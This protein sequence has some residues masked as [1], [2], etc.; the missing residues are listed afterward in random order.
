MLIAQV[1]YSYRPT[2]GGQE[3]LIQQMNELFSRLGHE[4]ITFQTDNGAEEERNLVLVKNKLPWLKGFD[5][6]SIS[7]SMKLGPYDLERF[8][9]VIFHY[10]ISWLPFRRLKNALVFSH[11]VEWDQMK[12][13]VKGIV[14]KR[15]AQYSLAR[16]PLVY[17]VANDKNYLRTVLENDL[18]F[19]RPYSRLAEGV[20]YIPNPVDVKKFQSAEPIAE[21]AALNP[22]LMPRN[23]VRERGLHIA[24]ESFAEVARD[25]PALH[26]IVA[27]E[28]WYA[29][30]NEYGRYISSLIRRNRLQGKVIFVGSIPWVD[31]ARYYKSSLVTVIPT[32]VGEGTSLA[33]LESMASGTPVVSSSTGGLS[34]LPTLK[35]SP[36]AISFA[37]ALRYALEN[38]DKLS[39]EQLQH[40]RDKFDISFWAAAWK[41]VLSEF[42]LR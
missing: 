33:A 32:L 12:S 31:M 4:V 20:W 19:L 10:A 5:R 25:F 29:R 30:T 15:V 35:S 8:D 2:N 3:I 13:G 16:A 40:T 26:L 41:Q 14:K 23:I 21:I 39:K 22:V 38:R 9:M 37:R 24:I 7:C 34:D 36:D 27:G 18:A 11:G 6:M 28:I 17:T 42:I 1:T